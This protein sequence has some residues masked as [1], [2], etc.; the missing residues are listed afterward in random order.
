MLKQIKNLKGIQ[1]MDQN[2]LSKCSGGKLSVECSFSDGP[3]WT[4]TTEDANVWY[5]MVQHCESNGGYV[6]DTW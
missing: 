5:E 4:G 3:G 2:S 6:E 1:V